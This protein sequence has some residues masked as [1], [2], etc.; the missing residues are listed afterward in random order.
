LWARERWWHPVRVTVTW[1][2]AQCRCWGCFS[3]APAE[4]AG[5]IQL[6]ISAASVILS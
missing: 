4:N 3:N 2:L 1:A 5:R 6:E